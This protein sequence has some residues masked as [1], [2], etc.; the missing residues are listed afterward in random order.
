VLLNHFVW[1]RGA[2][3]GGVG[4]LPGAGGRRFSLSEEISHVWQLFLPHLWLR[5]QFT[6]WPLWSMWFIGFVGRFG[7]LDY[8]FP[9]WFYEAA[10]VVAIAVCVL[11]AA[12]LLRS[13]R[14]MRPRLAELAVYALA[15]VGLA[16][17]IG[18][19]SYRYLI[20]NGG[21]FQQARYLLPLLCL[22]AAIVALAVRF[23]GRRWG[24]AVGALLVVLAIGHDLYAQGITIARYYG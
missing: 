8:G 5:P 7:W 23:G 1:S 10:R 20:T 18:V 24:P 22:Y 17:E 9:M 14:V 19:Q 4:S 3:P 15:V 13:R 11:A 21:V 16:G 12:E 6:S 2:I